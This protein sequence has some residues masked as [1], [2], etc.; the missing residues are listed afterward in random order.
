MLRERRC[1]KPPIC[2]GYLAKTCESRQGG[3][4]AHRSTRVQI[5][6][7]QP[8]RP[9]RHPLA[10]IVCWSTIVIVPEKVLRISGTKT[11]PRQRLGR[12]SENCRK[13]WAPIRGST[14]P[15]RESAL[16]FSFAQTT[17]PQIYLPHGSARICT[18]S[19]G[20]RQIPRDWLCA[21]AGLIRRAPPAP[22]ATIAQRRATRARF[23]KGRNMTVPST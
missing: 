22:A 5:C 9:M 12:S 20:L 14:P 8:I 16:A 15:F 19:L 18:L 6:D 1:A 2:S 21:G 3:Q 23:E 4:S 11:D 10:L 13:S 17:T 7:L